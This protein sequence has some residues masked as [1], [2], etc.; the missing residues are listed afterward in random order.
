V[1]V[2]FLFAGGGKEGAKATGKL[3]QY[4]WVTNKGTFVLSERIARKV[5]AGEKLVFKCSTWDPSAPFFKDVRDGMAQAES[6][7]PIDYKMVGPADG[8]V[9]KQIAELETLIQAEQVDGLAVSCG[10]ADILSPLIDKAWAKGIPILT[11]DN[12]SPNSKRLAYVGFIH[13]DIGK[14]GGEAMVKL[15]P[16]KTGKLAFFAAFPEGVYARGRIEGFRSVMD[17]HGMQWKTVGPFKLGLDMAE[18]YGVVENTFLAN[19][20]IEM[21]YTTDEF[22]QV[23]AEYVKRNNLADKV[24][25]VGV[26]DLPGVIKYVKENVVKQTT[27]INP[28]GQGYLTGKIIYEFVTTGKTAQ[29]ETYVKLDEITPATVDEFLKKKGQ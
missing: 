13:P 16:K 15:H 9:E 11:Y 25:V 8:V 23:P 14:L 1:S 6:E 7:F 2:S 21:V 4:K 17:K 5:A 3:Q 28:Y 22:V 12:D 20:D 26:N 18:G 24:L 29:S 19:P 10:D 27:G